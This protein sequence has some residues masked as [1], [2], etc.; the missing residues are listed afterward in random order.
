M[1][2]YS[3]AP[4]IVLYSFDS[5]DLGSVSSDDCS[6]V[7]FAVFCSSRWNL[8]EGVIDFRGIVP[9]THMFDARGGLKMMDRDADS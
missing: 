3:S 7:D 8:V 5:E 4:R 6:A 9:K 1:Q 2:V